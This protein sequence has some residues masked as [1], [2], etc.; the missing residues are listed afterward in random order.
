MSE[1]IS[2]EDRLPNE[3]GACLI[4]HFNGS[5][6]GYYFADT[7]LF[8]SDTYDFPEVTHWMPLPKAPKSGDVRLLIEIVVFVCAVAM[9]LAI[10]FGIY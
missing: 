8:D 10:T 3:E 5:D 7:K 9:V 1:W 6:C 2:V 4:V